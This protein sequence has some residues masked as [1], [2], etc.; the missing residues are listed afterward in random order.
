MSDNTK[1]KSA[2]S[3]PAAAEA[4]PGKK[5][6][7]LELMMAAR[8]KKKADGKGAPAPSSR[9]LGAPQG[10]SPGHANT[11]TKGGATGVTRRTAP[12]G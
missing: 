8:A 2:S 12:G 10:G 7:Q 9:A 3:K 11:H 1:N 4:A 6:T 5:P